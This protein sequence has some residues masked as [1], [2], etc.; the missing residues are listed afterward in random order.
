MIIIGI[1]AKRNIIINITANNTIT[2]TTNININTPHQHQHHHPSPLCRL[3]T[4]WAATPGDNARHTSHVTRNTSQF[5]HHTSHVIRHTT[6]VTLHTSHVTRHTSHVTRHTSH[7][8]RHTSCLLLILSS[9]LLQNA[10]KP[11]SES[12]TSCTG[13]PSV[14]LTKLSQKSSGERWFRKCNKMAVGDGG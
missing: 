4:V 6:H 11:A 9:L 2:I 5:T 12:T 1:T 10:S 3:T 14:Y 13:L 8:T 7:V